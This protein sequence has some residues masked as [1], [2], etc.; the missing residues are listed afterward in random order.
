MKISKIIVLINKS[1]GYNTG[2]NYEVLNKIRGV[3]IKLVV[4]MIFCNI[5][6]S[7]C[8]IKNN[9][10]NFEELSKELFSS[11][12]YRYEMHNS[13]ETSDG[14]NVY[15]SKDKMSKE[16][17][18]NV[19]ENKLINKGWR[20][21]SALFDDQYMYCFDRKNAISIVYPTRVNYRNEEGNSMSVGDWNLDKW[22][23]SYVYN[24]YGTTNCKK[25]F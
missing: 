18:E 16:D 15:I 25:I 4:I 23:I 5:F 13:K 19:V 9:R 11:Y 24:V 8:T 17:F 7:G 12:G 21:I 1:I 3:M 6:I 10:V 20:K 14:S 22:V 2:R